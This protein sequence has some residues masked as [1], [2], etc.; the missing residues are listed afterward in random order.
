V[1]F[2]TS[3]FTGVPLSQYWLFALGGLFVFVTLLMPKGI[4]G[5]VSD[6]LDNYLPRRKRKDGAVNAA[7]QASPAE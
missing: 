7:A 6:V 2:F 4:V 5:T 1:F 3:P